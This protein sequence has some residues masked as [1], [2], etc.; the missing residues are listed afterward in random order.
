MSGLEDAIPL[1]LGRR[2]K[3]YTEEERETISQ[4]RSYLFLRLLLNNSN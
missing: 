3:Q 2:A 4:T 1:G